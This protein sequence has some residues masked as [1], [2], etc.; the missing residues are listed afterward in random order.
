MTKLILPLLLLTLAFTPLSFAEDQVI[1]LKDGSQIK[2][3]LSGIAGGVYTVKTPIIGDIHVAAADVVSISKPSAAPAQASG[4]DKN[5][6][7][8][9]VEQAQT[10]LMANPQAMME[11]QALAQDPTL[12]PLLS[13]PALMQ[14]VT[15]KDASAVANN[16]KAQQLMNDPRMRRVMEMLQGDLQQQTATSK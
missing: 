15:S 6:L 14:A 1:T 3:E 2:G 9:R 11:L 12:A 10:Q 13:D 7:N 4:M 8:Q 16:P 5:N